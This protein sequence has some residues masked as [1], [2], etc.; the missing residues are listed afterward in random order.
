MNK[1][2]IVKESHTMGKT[3]P[4]QKIVGIGNYSSA[5]EI[6]SNVLAFLNL[7]TGHIL[8]TFIAMK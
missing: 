1:T 4:C 8:Y 5:N 2:I 3:K 7:Q 6:L